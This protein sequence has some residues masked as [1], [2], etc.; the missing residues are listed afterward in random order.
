MKTLLAL[1]AFIVLLT[2]AGPVSTACVNCDPSEPGP[3]GCMCFCANWADD[4]E[5]DD[6]YGTMSWR[7]LWIQCLNE[8]E[9]GGACD[10]IEEATGSDMLLQRERNMQ[11]P[12][13]KK[14]KPSSPVPVRRP[15]Q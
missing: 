11:K 9:A 8:Q 13:F 7:D 15:G 6:Q 2:A 5:Y 3:F 10:P 1:F 4:H 12:Q 14:E